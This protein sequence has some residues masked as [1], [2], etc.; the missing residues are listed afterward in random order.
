[1]TIKTLTMIKVLLLIPCILIFSCNPK[2]ASVDPSEKLNAL[3]VK[4]VRLG[5]DIGRYDEIFIDAYYGPDS[6]KPLTTKDSIFPKDSLLIAVGQLQ[7]EFSTFIQ[8]AKD[9]TLKMRAQWISGQLT[10]FS[11]RIKIFS[12]E[13]ASFDEESKQLY[14][15][16]APVHDEPYFQTLVAGLD[17][18]LPGKGSVQ[19][20]FQQLA[21]RFIIPKEKL[22]TVF[23]AAI[24]ECRQRTRKHYRLPESENFILE[25]VTDKSWGGYNWYKGNYQSVIQINTDLDIFV[26]RAI[27]VGSHESY[28][29]HHVYNMLLEKNLYHDRGWVEIS[30]YPLFSPQSLIAEGSA[31]YGIEVVLPGNEKVNFAKDV[32]LPLAGIDTSGTSLY[33]RAL[34]VKGKLNYARNEVARGLINKTMDETEAL[35]WLKEYCLLNDE[36][37]KKSIR[38]IDANRSYIINYNYGQELVANYI[39]SRGGTSSA[40][41][42][43]WELFSWLLSNPVTPQQLLSK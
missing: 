41:D 16:T 42:K 15:V 6:L 20:K 14:G 21:N 34:E 7:H 43:R 13:F 11:Q 2:G 37:A 31:N 36:T 10:A 38:F 24:A 12:G 23:K 5:L 8:E 28:P 19:D 26:D 27:D 32:L 9:D 29:G 33:F 30:V 39:E 4:Y 1:M 40:P 35:R 17:S 22:D 18:V 25:F 3:A